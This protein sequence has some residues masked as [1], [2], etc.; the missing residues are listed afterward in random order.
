MGIADFG[1]D[2]LPIGEYEG[3]GKRLRIGG[4]DL[5]IDAEI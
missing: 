4:N 5:C 1:N 3:G 2:G